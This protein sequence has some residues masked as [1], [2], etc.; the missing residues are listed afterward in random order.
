MKVEKESR[1]CD[2]CGIELEHPAG[3]EFE[4]ENFRGEIRISLMKLAGA[5]A[6][7]CSPCA[8]TIL[9]KAVIKYGEP[10]T[11]RW[12]PKDGH[13]WHGFQG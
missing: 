6:D 11:T 10:G 3:I 4:I 9:K 7:F 13:P 1:F 8:E 2:V 5:Y 12:M